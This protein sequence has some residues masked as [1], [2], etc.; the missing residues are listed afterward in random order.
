[1]TNIP[2]KNPDIL[3]GNDVF[4]FF[5]D[6]NGSIEM[7]INPG[8]GANPVRVHDGGDF[9]GWTPSQ[10]VGTSVNF[11]ST[12]HIQQGT[13]TVIQFANLTGEN[14]VITGLNVTGTP[15]TLTEGVEWTAATSNA[16]TA[17]SIATAVSAIAGLVGTSEG[18]VV[19]IEAD[20]AQEADL[21]SITTNAAAGDMVTKA[22]GIDMTGMVNGDQVLFTAPAPIT[23]DTVKSLAISQYIQTW[24]TQGIAKELT[25][26]F[27]L[28][29]VNV[30][31]SVDLSRF[32][33]IG[34]QGTWR[35]IL[36]GLNQFGLTNQSIDEMLVT[37]VDT[38][39][40]EPV[41]VWWDFIK[42]E[43]AGAPAEFKI[44]VAADF[45]LTTAALVFAN[46]GPAG[47]L[48]K[49]TPTRPN[50]W[51]SIDRLPIGHRGE[52]I[53][54][55]IPFAIEI[56][57][58]NFDLESASGWARVHKPRT[59]FTPDNTVIKTLYLEVGMGSAGITL[60]PGDTW[61][62]FINDDYSAFSE[63]RM[64]ISG[65]ERFIG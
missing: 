8:S 15:V 13:A 32:T 30:G 19:F 57:T 1:M 43:T 61:T 48:T 18:A 49:D 65:P 27:R 4:F 20:T 39:T 12:T 51:F 23:A 46:V 36:I 45:E 17:A 22:A 34:D 28:S 26:Q 42:L 16:A 7:N 38:G 52:I 44:V 41:A 62:Q 53:S 56:V 33:E 10:P 37:N 58:Q 2:G 31:N 5:T 63:F 35:K 24:T 60:G 21:V 50:M 47:D 55:G 40:G 14:I 29:G 6:E 59:D 64:S 25:V 54:G 11:A 3:T 9:T